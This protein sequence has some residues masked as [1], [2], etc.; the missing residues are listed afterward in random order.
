MTMVAGGIYAQCGG[1]M[2][3]ARKRVDEIAGVV[4]ATR[5]RLPP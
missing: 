2:A 4:A 5:R 3:A 1:D